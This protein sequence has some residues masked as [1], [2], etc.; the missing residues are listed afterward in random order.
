[1]IT[2]RLFEL[3]ADDN[4]D[5]PLK[6]PLIALSRNKDV[7]LLSNVKSSKTYDGIKLHSTEESTAQLNVIPIKLLF[8]S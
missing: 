4:K 2:K 1:M 8:I 5:A 7:E 6:L 3:S